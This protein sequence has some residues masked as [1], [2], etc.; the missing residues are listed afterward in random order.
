MLAP[1]QWDSVLG[2]ISGTV[3]RGIERVSSNALLSA[4]DVGPDPIVR[5]QVAKRVRPTMKRLGWIGPRGITGALPGL[6]AT[7]GNRREKALASC[8][9]GPMAG[10]SCG[11]LEE[12]EL[13][14]R[15]RGSLARPCVNLWSGASITRSRPIPTCTIKHRSF[16]N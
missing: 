13:R 3:H 15:V 6:A 9:C 14:C 12:R 7:G 16:A 1:D 11:A 10:L 5:Q 8:C 2:S 4:L